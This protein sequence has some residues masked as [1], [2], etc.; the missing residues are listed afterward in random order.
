MKYLSF[1]F[2]FFI[3]VLTPLAGQVKI[4]CKTDTVWIAGQYN[5]VS[6][7]VTFDASDGLVRFT[8][9]F[10]EG[11][12]VAPENIPAGDFSWYNNQLNIVWLTI[13][14]SKKISFSYLVMPGKS[15]SGSFDLEGRLVMITGGKT[16]RTFSMNNIKV[17]IKGAQTSEAVNTEAGKRNVRQD[18]RGDV[19]SEPRGRQAAPSD[20]NIEFRVQVASYSTP[21]P[22]EQVAKK[23]GLWPGE[24]LVMVKVGNVYKYQVGSFSVYEEAV[25]LQKRLAASGL[26]DAFVVAY[27]GETQIPVSEAIR[28]IK[29]R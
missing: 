10:P 3:F 11:V 18:G 17:S 9:D 26:K 22:A 16:K 21:L 19:V 2:C 27:S 25:A 15:M 8:Q 20:R 28:I 29:S 24:K 23:L 12:E 4:V 1:I 6:V 14:A 5:H 13:P 7:D